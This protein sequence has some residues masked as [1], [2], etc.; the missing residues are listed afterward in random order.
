MLTPTTHSYRVYVTPSR[1][2]QNKYA[3]YIMKEFNMIKIW[4][5]VASKHETSSI[6]F[7]LK[8]LHDHFTSKI[9]SFLFL[10]LFCCFVRTSVLYSAKLLQFTALP[11]LPY[12][13]YIAHAYILTYMH[14]YIHGYIAALQHDNL[15]SLCRFFCVCTFHWNISWPAVKQRKMFWTSAQ[16]VSLIN[17][18]SFTLNT[19]SACR[20]ENF[21]DTTDN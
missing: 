6:T 2:K 19:L 17:D 3:H 18:V 9:L 8:S 13:K 5:F 21:S 10:A 7:L 20:M 16:D 12:Y 1:E 11:I 14:K 4:V 15:K